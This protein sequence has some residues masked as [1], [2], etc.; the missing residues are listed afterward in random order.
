MKLALFISKD[1]VQHQM[2]SEINRNVCEQTFDIKWTHYM[3]RIKF[4]VI[5]FW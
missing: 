5:S 4:M 3:V 1:F 2:C